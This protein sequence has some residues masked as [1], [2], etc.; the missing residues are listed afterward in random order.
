MVRGINRTARKIQRIKRNL[1]PN[2]RKSV[3]Q[4]TAQTADE[5]RANVVTGGQVWR[6]NLAANIR[7]RITEDGKFVASADVPYA[8]FVEFGTGPRQAPDTPPE[9]RFKAPSM[10]PNLV[11]GIT[12]WVMTK[13][14][15]FGERSFGTA[16]AIAH[17]IS[18]KGTTAHPFMRPAWFT[19]RPIL[20]ERAGQAVKNTVGRA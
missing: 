18:E 5:A 2:V 19:M 6:G 3:A 14:G 11:S 7:M 10:G 15:F 4:S 8:A 13:P 17:S 16:I 9:F 20:I 12:G 1:G